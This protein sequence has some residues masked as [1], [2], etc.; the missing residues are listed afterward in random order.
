MASKIGLFKYV[1]SK[2]IIKQKFICL[3]NFIMKFI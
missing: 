2:Q 1:S 3:S